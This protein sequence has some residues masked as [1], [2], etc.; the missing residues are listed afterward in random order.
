MSA[1]DLQ[2]SVNPNTVQITKD[3]GLIELELNIDCEGAG[4]LAKRLI[5]NI[6]VYQNG[7]TRFVI[8]EPGSKRF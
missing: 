7:I 2:Y 8:G 6:W 4:Y 3:A 5:A 1:A